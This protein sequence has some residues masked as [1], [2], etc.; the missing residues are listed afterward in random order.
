[1]SPIFYEIL[2][3]NLRKYMLTEYIPMEYNFNIKK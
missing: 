3:I 1:M 2:L